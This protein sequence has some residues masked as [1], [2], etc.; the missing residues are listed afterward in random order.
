[1][2]PQEQ[3]QL[4]AALLH[5]SVRSRLEQELAEI[6]LMTS[7][8]PKAK[9]TKAT[10]AQLSRAEKAEAWRKQLQHSTVSTRLN[11]L[12]PAAGKQ[13]EEGSQE[14]LGKGFERKADEQAESE[15]TE[16]QE[17][18][19]E[20][21]EAAKK[22]AT[23]AAEQSAVADSLHSA[24][25]GQTVRVICPQAGYLWQNKKGSVEKA[26]GDKVTVLMAGTKSCRSEVPSKRSLAVD[27]ER[28]S[29]FASCTEFQKTDS[30]AEAASSASQRE[31][32]SIY[33][34]HR[35][36]GRT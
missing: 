23:K 35:D 5:P 20:M 18:S 14:T 27:W 26:K 16:G 1:M 4:T 2:T 13:K 12:T 29:S 28:E 31:R 9:S 21:K 33:S 30:F 15:Q 7:Q 6:T 32:A 3:L 22:A 8:K 36:A 11:K 10:T 25:V 34:K 17:R 19:Q 24:L